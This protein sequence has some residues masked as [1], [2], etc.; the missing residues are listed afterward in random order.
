MLVSS[1]ATSKEQ[2]NFDFR[3]FGLAV[4]RAREAKGWTQEHLAQLVGLTPRS[5]RAIENDCQHPC[6]NTICQLVMLLDVSIDQY[7]FSADIPTNNARINRL[8]W[9]L[10]TLKENELNMIDRMIDAVKENRPD[11]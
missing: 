2:S 11:S 3:A 1:M 6:F 4:K 10:N 8:T 9:K 5:I 7:F